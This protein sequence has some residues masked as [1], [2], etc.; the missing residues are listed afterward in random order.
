MRT[1]ASMY[2]SRAF[3]LVEAVVAVVIAAFVVI[4]VGGL[5]ERLVHHRTTTDSNSAALSLAEWK[6]EKLIADTT[7]NPTNPNCS[8]PTTASNLCG[9][10]VTYGANGNLCGDTTATGA[11]HGPFPV[12]VVGNASNATG[13]YCVAWRVIDA[14]TSTSPASPLVMPSSVPTPTGGTAPTKRITVTVTH[15]RN[16]QVNAKVVVQFPPPS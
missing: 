12:D 5:G 13:P 11:Q 8:G 2:N 7:P 1:A 9:S 14:S 16:P 15:V 4:A 6:M 10:A 3:T